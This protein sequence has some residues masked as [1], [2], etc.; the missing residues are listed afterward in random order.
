M[1]WALF[2]PTILKWYGP[3]DSV[4]SRTTVFL[5]EH[6]IK[7]VAYRS[8]QWSAYRWMDCCELRPDAA[9]P[10]QYTMT[11][12]LNH[13]RGRMLVDRVRKVALPAGLNLEAV[14]G[15]LA[16]KGVRVVRLG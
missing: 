15:I 9:I 13:D 6:G 5:T 3:Y 14:C 1:F 11:F 7:T 8:L 2:S 16:C 4:L 12:A 10:Q